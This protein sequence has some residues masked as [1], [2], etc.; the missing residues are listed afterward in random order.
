MDADYAL[1]AKVVEAGSLSAAGRSLSISPGMV[2]KRLARVEARLGVRLLHRTTRKLALTEAGERFHAD[3]VAIL[4]AVREAENRLTGVRDEPSG[5][6]RVSAPTSFGRLHVAPYLHAFIDT[7]PRVD[8]ELDLTDENADLFSGRIDL[9]VRIAADIP[10]SL[11]AHRLGE[12]RR[13]LCA[14]PSYLD[15]H[16]VPDTVAALAHHSLL[17]ATGQMPWR[18]VNGTRRHT[19]E[20]R[21]HIRTNSSEIV[22][23]LAITGVGIALRSFWDV[24]DALATGRLVPVLP[25]WGGS[26]GLGIH[27]VHPRAPSVPAA[28]TAFVDFLKRSLEPAPWDHPRPG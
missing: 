13:L 25:G 10:T 28:V 21:S 14:S 16:G 26:S 15:R 8:L 23:E 24:G 4:H 5:V 20:G 11:E 1:F 12:S 27:A 17:A 6:L 9:A 22:R 2:S 3:V 19:V 18:L 7:H